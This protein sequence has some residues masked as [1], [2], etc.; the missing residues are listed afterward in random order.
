MRAVPGDVN[1]QSGPRRSV[2]ARKPHEQAVRRSA[3]TLAE[4]HPRGA[5]KRVLGFLCPIVTCLVVAGC[6]EGGAPAA[7]LPV[8]GEA[9][10]ASNTIRITSGINGSIGAG[11][12][13]SEVKLQNNQSDF[14]DV[15]LMVTLRKSTS[16]E[17]S[18]K[19]MELARWREG[20]V[21]TIGGFAGSTSLFNSKNVWNKIDI[22]G[23]AKK[24]NDLAT[25]DITLE[26][27]Y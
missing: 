13:A 19:T 10:P 7:L 4:E 23:D 8:T 27:N 24:G 18:Q 2:G 16:A 1:P 21:I 3:R 11:L 6:D 25:I 9:K 14:T 17:V 15:S 12:V 5:C 22:K 20:E 26:I